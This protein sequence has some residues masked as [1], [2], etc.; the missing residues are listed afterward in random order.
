MGTAGS[1][2]FRRHERPWTPP[3]NLDSRYDNS[4]LL[5]GRPPTMILHRVIKSTCAFVIRLSDPL[6]RAWQA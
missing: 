4:F 6:I 1:H 5:S 3:H 2:G